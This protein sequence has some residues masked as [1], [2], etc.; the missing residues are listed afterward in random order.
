MHTAIYLTRRMDI[1]AWWGKLPTYI[2]YFE[3]DEP[4]PIPDVFARPSFI[5]LVSLRNWVVDSHRRGLPACWLPR[6]GLFV[7][8]WIFWEIVIIHVVAEIWFSPPRTVHTVER[9]IFFWQVVLLIVSQ[10][11][12]QATS[13]HSYI[14]QIRL[15]SQLWQSISLGKTSIGPDSDRRLRF[16]LNLP[17]WPPQIA[18]HGQ[19]RY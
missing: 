17:T 9:M 5:T 7:D 3:D 4:M 13:K 18:C 6:S 8:S 1:F 16:L 2:R 10:Q 14:N 12:L 15:W 11:R 19:L